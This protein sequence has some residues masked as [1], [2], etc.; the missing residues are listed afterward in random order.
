MH[1]TRGRFDILGVA[2]AIVISV[3][4]A[5]AQTRQP[6]IVLIVGD[7]MG[8]GDIGVHFSKDIPTPNIDAL[9]RAGVRFTDAYVTGPHCSPTRA[10]LLTGRYQQRVGHE[11]NMGADAGP[12]GGLPASETTLADRL[13]AAGYRTA[14]LG[15]GILDPQ[16]TFTRCLEASTS[17][18]GSSAVNIRTSNRHP[19]VAILSTKA[20]LE[21]KRAATLPS[22]GAGSI[23]GQSFSSMS[24]RR[25]SG[26]RAS[27][28]SRNGNSIA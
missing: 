1:R 22:P 13:K 6:N 20:A 17:S 10:G 23:R 16:S 25:R 19:T 11:V 12:N 8:Y 7:E 14:L 2:L 15:S 21:S 3:C 9:A 4:T 24:C 18:T 28:Q 27:K 5:S 26:P